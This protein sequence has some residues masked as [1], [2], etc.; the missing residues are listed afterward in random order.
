M[1][2]NV[3]WFQRIFHNLIEKVEKVEKGDLFFYIYYMKKCSRCNI[4]K[5]LK[6]FYKKK[7]SKDGFRSECKECDY[8]Y[9]KK[10]K[11][12][13][14]LTHK[15]SKKEKFDKEKF[16]LYINQYRKSNIDKI[17]DKNK[18]YRDKNKEHLNILR[19]E[20][21]KDK[22][23]T[24]EIFKIKH[25]IRSLISTSFKKEG[26]K[27]KSKTNLILGCSFEE[28][29]IHIETQF[30]DGMSWEN[31][32]E[33]HLDHKTPISWA[34]TEEEIYELNHYSNFQPLWAKD[35]IVKGNK[36]SD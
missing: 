16:K 31:H 35:N 34:K 9:S 18:E 24:D 2:L 28:F 29:K 13:Y 25:N 5:D 33:W 12:K 6:Y 1:L 10:Y 20:Y 26:Y 36:W 11:I 32:G 8:H 17:R 23:L 15:E 27:K 19:N 22:F 21:R 3:R 30:K 14:H 4:E 7:S